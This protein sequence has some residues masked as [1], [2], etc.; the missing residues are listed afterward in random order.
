MPLNSSKEDLVTSPLDAT[1]HRDSYTPA[2]VSLVANDLVWGGSSVFRHHFDLGTNEWRVLSAL[3]NYPGSTAG[4]LCEVLGMN[5]SIASK[6][7]NLLVGRRLVAQVDGARG[8]RPLYLTRAGAHTHDRMIRIALRR[9]E[10]LHSE[11]SE[12]EVSQLH[13][14]LLKLLEIGP[15]LHEYEQNLCRNPPGDLEE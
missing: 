8:S 13:Q 9:Q 14:L 7:V 15:V 10:I 2:L 3:G 1:I 11:L 12:E 4:E 6:S 5:K